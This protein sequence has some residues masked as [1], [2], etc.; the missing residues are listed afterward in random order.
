MSGAADALRAAQSTSQARGQW[1]E[2]Q[3]AADAAFLQQ[4]QA[5]QERRD[6]EAQA[7]QQAWESYRA[8]ERAEYAI[9]ACTAPEPPKPWWQRAGEWVQQKVVQPV[10]QAIPKVMNWVDRHQ[11]EIA[12]GIGIAAGVAA[13]V[14]SGGA[15][16]PLV[17]AAWVAG[18]AAVA[19]GVVA[20]GTV[21]LNAYFHRPLTTN[22]WRNVGYAAG[23]A[24]V[25]AT[26]GFLLSGGVVQQGL[27]S[28]GNAATRLCITHPSGCARVGAALE[29][30]DKVEDIGLQAKLAI[31]TAQG[32]PRA[33]ETALEL[34][35]ER[36]D[37]TPGNTTFREVQEALSTLVGRHGDDV[38]QLVG[39]FGMEGAKLLA[40]HQDDGVEFLGRH[41]DEAEDVSRYVSNVVEVDLANLNLEQGY[42]VSRTA[43]ELDVPIA[44]TGRWA[45]T[46]EEAAMRAQSVTRME[47]LM[48]AGILPE[49]AIMQAAN[50]FGI[51]PHQ[52]KISTDKP[53]VDVVIPK[54]LWDSL[55]P[56]Q[57]NLIRQ[58]L[59]VFNVDGDSRF[60]IDFYQNLSLEKMEKYGWPDPR[61]NIPPGS[62]I[63]N[64]DGSIIHEP[65][66]AP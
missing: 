13:V 5:E 51:N 28:V 49:D 32:D 22:L 36:L 41:L 48:T 1:I 17:A 18:S 9:P 40:K 21:G 60:E 54:S 30:W 12:L 20:A 23:A 52:V 61:M 66:A 45:D 31:Q 34:Q 64:P 38:A 53:E 16:T 24:A 29:L 58:R 56:E 47:E 27:Y 3:E 42:V 44:I 33:A 7:R 6:E 46:P 15:A 8:G 55:S 59:E 35:L 14:L 26:A 57:Q 11:P 43:Q 63:F 2:Q 4:M 37:N 62:I 10:Q 19:G 65:F 25:T 39:R 50:E